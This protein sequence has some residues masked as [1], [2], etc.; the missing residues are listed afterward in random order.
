MKKK[1]IFDVVS[2]M[3]QKYF[4]LVWYARSYKNRN[5]DVVLEHRARIEKLHPNEIAKLNDLDSSDWQHGFNSGM[6]A[7]MRYVHSLAYEGKDI[8]EEDFPFLDT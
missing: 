7:G 3:E 5:L 2:E 4:E 8:A 1:E 6:L